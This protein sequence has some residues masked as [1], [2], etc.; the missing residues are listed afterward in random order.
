MAG[1]GLS[2][3]LAAFLE[4]AGQ[5]VVAAFMVTSALFFFA[6]IMFFCLAKPIKNHIVRA[7]SPE[8][9]KITLASIRAIW[10]SP[11]WRPV[12]MVFI[13]ANVFAGV[14]NFQTVYADESGLNYADYFLIYTVTVVIFRLVLARFSARKNPY[15]T[16]ALLQY[17]VCGSVVLFCFITGDQCLYW[18]FAVLFGIGY[19]VSYPILVTMTARDTSGGLVVQTLQL[20]A[21]PYFAGIFGFT[22]V[23]GWIIVDFG[24]I[25]LLLLLAG[26]AAVEAS[27]VLARLIVRMRH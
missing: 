23:A 27:M 13:G 18:L 4:V 5:T 3:V 16:M 11:A 2:Q 10:R 15:F 25:S 8:Q 6:A 14:S 1:F 24:S 17:V 20:F 9:S 21:F 26:I 19:G 22:L 7:R 12:T